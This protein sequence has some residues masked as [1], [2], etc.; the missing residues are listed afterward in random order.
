M[1]F[2]TIGTCLQRIFCL[3]LCA[4]APV[5][6]ES[7][8]NAPEETPPPRD[9]LILINYELGMHCTG[10]D[11]SYCCVL[12]PYNSILAQVVRTERKGEEPVLLRADPNDPEVLVD[13]ERRFKLAYTHEDPDGIPN[14]YSYR[15]KLLYWGVPHK[16][17]GLPNAYF[18]NLYF[19]EDLEGS[20]PKNTTADDR[21]KHVGLASKI[22]F[23]EGPTGQHVGHGF[24]RYSGD[25]GTR[26]FADSPAMENVPIKLTNP[27]IWEALG[28]PLTP[29]NDRFTQLITLDETMVQPF[30]RSVVTLVDAKTEEPVIDSSGQPV[31]FFGVNPIDVPNC[32]RCHSNERANGTKYTKYKDEYHFWKE[33][34]GSREWYAELKAAA[35]SILEIHDDRHGTNFLAKWP[36]NGIAE[37]RLG[38]P[39]VLCQDCHADN[40][41]GQL[42]SRKAGEMDAEDIRKGSDQL[43]APDHLISP[44]TE[45]IHIGHQR[46][47]PLSDS[48]GFAGGCQLCHPSHRSDRSMNNFPLTA[49]GYNL[50]ARGDVR[51]AKGCF[52]GRDVHANPLR[53]RDGAGTAS[54]LNAVGEYL[55]SEVMTT[56]NGDKG[57]YCTHC[58][59]RLSRELYKADHLEDAVR[60]DGDTLR[61]A[62]LDGIASGLGVTKDA[63]IRDYLDPR[64]PLKGEDTDS[65]VLRTWDRQGQKIADIARIKVDD[66]GQIVMTQPDEDGDRSVIV[67]DP[68]PDGHEGLAVPYDAATHGRDYWLAPGEPHCADCHRPPFV[69]SMGGGAFPIDQPGKYA[70]MRYSKGHSG[71]SC[72]GC[73]ESTHGLYPVNPAVDITSYQQAAMLNPDGSHGPLKCGAC[74]RVNKDGVPS[75]HVDVITKDGPYWSD[76]AKAVELQH[77]LR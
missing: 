17:S 32:A 51:D 47:T 75:R 44:L 56:D 19:Y 36:A 1:K 40:V 55:L 48:Q 58:H 76:Y 38:R 8:A 72:Q 29:F 46:R 2:R 4:I 30:M 31:R 13:G 18:S 15:K 10:F 39:T 25:T 6:A 28:L 53:K 37:L 9:Y 61:A 73:H 68:D 67:V 23:N 71:I 59:N 14:T 27:G 11:F 65:G 35:I 41:V 64:V 45:A 3:L 57:L 54:H 12:P 62:S 22:D 24:L 34:R 50:F 43:P 52:T 26:V 42:F 16:K 20:N 21:K 5:Q 66:K 49:D 63:L 70:L 69:E 60:Q 33:I 77:T 7:P 74:H